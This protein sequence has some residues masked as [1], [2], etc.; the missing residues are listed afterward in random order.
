MIVH[1]SSIVDPS[2]VL[3][4]DVRVYEFT[5]ILAGTVVGEGSVIGGRCFI[6]MDCKSGRG[7][8]IQDGCFL[9]NRTVVEDN[10][11]LGPNV[12]LTDDRYP[13]AGNR[14][15]K[16]EPPVIRRGASLGAGVTVLPG[17]TIGED[18]MIGAGAVVIRD[19]EPGLTYIGQSPKVA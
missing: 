19:V 5:S 9:P 15:Y 1:P 4:V 13:R 11:F 16:A 7:V 18:A 8:R 3:E 6:G 17:V 10:A 12:T 14:R 2:A